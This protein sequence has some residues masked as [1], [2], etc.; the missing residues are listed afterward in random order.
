MERIRYTCNVQNKYAILKET[1]RNLCTLSSKAT[2]LAIIDIKIVNHINAK[3]KTNTAK[4]T[5]VNTTHR[6]PKIVT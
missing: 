5:T 4:K 3:N 2:P 1:R 6:Q